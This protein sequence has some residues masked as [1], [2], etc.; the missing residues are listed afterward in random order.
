MSGPPALRRRMDAVLGASGAHTPEGAVE[1]AT[2]LLDR[3]L[4]RDERMSRAAALDLLV[5]D[6]LVTG[7]FE[8]AS[9][10]PARVGARAEWAMRR[11]AA[12]GEQ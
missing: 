1:A 7:A 10:E 12:L 8:A 5:A 11:I 6:A 3:L 2:A 9:D 4:L